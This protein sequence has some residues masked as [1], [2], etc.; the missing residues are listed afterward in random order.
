MAVEIYDGVERDGTADNRAHGHSALSPKLAALH[1][2][3]ELAG[4]HL[5]DPLRRFHRAAKREKV[6]RHDLGIDW[7]LHQAHHVLIGTRREFR[8]AARG[9][10]VAHDGAQRC[11]DAA[12]HRKLYELRERRRACKAYMHGQADPIS[13]QF[14]LPIGNRVCVE[15]ELRHDVYLDAGSIRKGLL[16]LE[17]VPQQRWPDGLSAFGMS[18]D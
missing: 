1:V 16:G 11:P 10:Q 13:R 8:D 14:A 5:P 4:A 17:G 3:L 6:R 7:E 12:Q 18:S 15:A 2:D 9:A